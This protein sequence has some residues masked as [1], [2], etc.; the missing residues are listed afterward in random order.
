MR[1][2]GCRTRRWKRLQF[3][4]LDFSG[5][6]P[7]LHAYSDC[8]TYFCIDLTIALIFSFDIS[9]RHEHLVLLQRGAR[10]LTILSPV[11]IVYLEL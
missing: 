2:D 9:S 4:G 7:E 6:R 5:I 10:Q 8:S 1:M 11:L 3:L